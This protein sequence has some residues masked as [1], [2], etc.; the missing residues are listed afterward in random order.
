[1]TPGFAVTVVGYKGLMGE[2]D[3]RLGRF[4]LEQNEPSFGHDTYDNA[5]QQLK[6]GHKCTHWMWYVFPQL[7]FGTTATS[8]KF[9]ISGL[10]EARAYLAHPK[11]RTRLHDC[12]DAVLASPTPTAAALVGDDAAKLKSSMTLFL[13]ADPEDPRYQAVLDKYFGGK[14]DAATDKRL[15]LA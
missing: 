13:R 1:M 2:I 11:L 3:Y 4:V 14:P 10:E 12:V 7:E 6:D 5:L 8:K 15:G 9:S